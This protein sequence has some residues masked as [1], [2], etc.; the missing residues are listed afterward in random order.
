MS[1]ADFQNKLLQDVDIAVAQCIERELA[2]HTGVTSNSDTENRHKL[3]SYS[4]YNMVSSSYTKLKDNLKDKLLKDVELPNAGEQATLLD[5][6]IGSVVLKVRSS[7][8]RIDN[9]KFM[10]ELRV[11]GVNQDVINKAL[12]A[13]TSETAPAKVIEVI[14]K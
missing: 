6:P 10:T 12:A 13:A 5:T 2:S 1:F 7:S 11:A 8:T 9:V 14:N 4:A 3:L